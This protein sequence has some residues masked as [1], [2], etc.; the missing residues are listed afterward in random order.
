MR[1]HACCVTMAHNQHMENSQV[2]MVAGLP[3]LAT[4]MHLPEWRPGSVSRPRLIEALNR[5]PGRKLSLI[6]APAGF[7]KTT[8]LAEWLASS[9]SEKRTAAWVSLD[10]GDNDP[11]LFWTYVCSAILSADGVIGRQT[12]SLLRTPHPPHIDSVLTLLIN[13]ISTVEHEILLV[14][15]DLH[16][17]ESE[18]IHRA[19]AFLLDHLPPR[20]HLIITTRADP[21]LPLARL[22][23]RGEMTELRASDLRFTADE[24]AV[25]LDSA[26]GLRLS[27]SDVEVLERRTEGWIAGLQLAALSMQGQRDISGFIRSFAGDHRYI[28]D[29]LVE[30]VLS[31]QPQRVKEFLLQTSILDR[32][33]G[34][35]C[36]AVTGNSDG[37]TRLAELERGNFFVVPLD[38]RR[39]WYRYHHLFADV[40]RARL[41]EEQPEQIKELHRRAS[42]WFAEKASA[43]EAINHAVVSGDLERAA[44][45]V[46]VSV[47]P[48]QRSRQEA[49]V[50]G[51][52][53]LLPDDL[54]RNRPVLCLAYT[55][56]LLSVG[57]I[58]EV[59]SWLQETERWVSRIEDA[60]SS[61]VACL[62]DMVVVDKVEYGRLPA[63]CEIYRSALALMREDIDETVVRARHALQ[64]ITADDLLGHG[65]AAAILGLASWRSGDLDDAYRSYGEGMES[66][67]RAGNISDVVGGAIAPADIRMTQGRLRDAKNIFERAITL[68]REQG[69]PVVRGTADMYV[70]LCEIAL[71]RGEIELAIGHLQT[72]QELGEHTGFR[73][74]PYRSRVAMAR[75]KQIRGEFDAAIEL[76]NEAER[77]YTSDFFPYV[78]P[79]DAMRARV[80]IAQ[81]R[82][83]EALAWARERGLSA[84]KDP[85]YLREFDLITLAKILLAQTTPDV[86]GSST[87]QAVGLLV[88]LRE[89]AAA[90]SR[91]GSEIEILVHLAIAQYCGTSEGAALLSLR[92]AI[93]LAEPEGYV[94]VFVDGGEPIRHL[95]RELAAAGAT[96]FASKLLSFFEG[97][98]LAVSAPSEKAASQLEEPLTAREIEIL[99]LIESGMRNQEIADRLYISLPTVKRHVANAYG[100]LGVSHRTEAIARAKELSLL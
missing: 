13:E 21:P 46:E 84:D 82:V 43:S 5:R 11:T 94:R 53:R 64:L 40:L 23:G 30:E 98:T 37:F 71:E 10:A 93:E 92:R 99:R 34:A 76:L 54:V 80:L 9:K 24:A 28:V 45:L 77:Q 75:I 27:A 88:R 1:A 59:E 72:A 3:L 67:R 4:K 100:K 52:L 8:L 20:M 17:I 50:L 56:I 62:R 89:A 60:G 51:W 91:H 41:K 15:D 7:G 2:D 18:P 29:Y 70:G 31:R 78:R 83:G 14:L 73:Q 26:M 86:C 57:E 58:G 47:R 66:L 36:D 85:S 87:R 25:F 39:L 48:A 55:G 49:T 44:E 97:T 16:V 42:D 74:Y 79:I 68:S 95:L 63:W 19:L 61:G 90:G 12:L 69:E 35:L 81:G 32:L 96:P 6:S 22:R 65:A 38:D 33:N